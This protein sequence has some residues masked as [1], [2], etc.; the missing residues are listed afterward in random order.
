MA[1]V[2]VP[3]L[4]FN[5]RKITDYTRDLDR[6][7]LLTRPYNNVNHFLWILGHITVIRG[8]LI[9]MLGG[10]ATIDAEESKLFGS[11]SEIS[12]Q[13]IYPPA[14]KILSCFEERGNMLCDLLDN[15][16][17]EKLREESPF[18]FAFGEKVLGDTLNFLYWHEV[19]HYGELNYLHKMLT[20]K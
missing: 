13:D 10:K 18:K 3:G 4:R 7:Q 2:Y 1:N 19:T 16:T 9:N 14:E 8:N 6:Q 12:T 11:R 20:R 17:E 5:T 15:I